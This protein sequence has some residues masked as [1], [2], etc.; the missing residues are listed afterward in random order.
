MPEHRR[1]EA[2]VS[3][4]VVEAAGKLFLQHTGDVRDVAD[5]IVTVRES[6]AGQRWPTALASAVGRSYLVRVRCLGVCR[7][8]HLPRD[9][10]A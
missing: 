3:A 10:P 5:R 7:T 1:V 2:R 6:V 8:L 4:P 9:F